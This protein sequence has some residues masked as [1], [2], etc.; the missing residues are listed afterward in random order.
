MSVIL[1]DNSVNSYG[2]RV[3]SEGGDF[4]RFLK[5]PVL[6]DSHD[7]WDSS[8]VMGLWENLR[9]EGDQVLADPLFD[10]EDPKAAELAR[11]YEKG[12]IK[13]SSIGFRVLATS[14]DPEDMVDGQIYP[15]VTKWELMEA[16]LVPI[17]SNGNA[18]RLYDKTGNQV[19]LQEPDTLA[20]AL[21]MNS[22][23]ALMSNKPSNPEITKE[24]L[25]AAQKLMR[26]LGIK[27]QVHEGDDSA[28]HKPDDA[29]TKLQS[30]YDAV[31][32][33]RDQFQTKLSDR[34]QTIKELRAELTQE[35]KEKSDL[36]KE[37]KRLAAEAADESADHTP[38]NDPAGQ[39]S[40]QGTD[41]FLTDAD[42]KARARWDAKPKNK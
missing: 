37:V 8:S 14:E 39:G 24:T 6:L 17:P 3:L 42:R 26:A 30:D 21:G 35:K 33:E 4:Q 9:I 23:Q 15:T 22:N 20:L 36:S 10:T 11:K 19:A 32:T 40:G 13:A 2:F 1:T 28:E 38:D 5:N 31:V 12:F 27:V 41:R 29:L 18:V 7:N 25:S 34:D 16:S